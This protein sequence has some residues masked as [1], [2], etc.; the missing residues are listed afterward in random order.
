LP[1]NHLAALKTFKDYLNI[2]LMRVY[3]HSFSK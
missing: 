2:A 3:V 1:A